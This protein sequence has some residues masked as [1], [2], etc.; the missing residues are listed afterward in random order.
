MFRYGDCTGQNQAKKL[1]LQLQSPGMDLHMS[2]LYAPEAP[3]CH[4]RG[5]FYA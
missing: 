5:L 2:K 3:P 1:T 4:R